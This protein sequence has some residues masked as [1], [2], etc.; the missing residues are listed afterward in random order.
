MMEMK[1]KVFGIDKNLM[2]KIIC[3]NERT[4][5]VE[6][7]DDIDIEVGD[8]ISGELMNYGGDVRLYSSNNGEYFDALI[9]NLDI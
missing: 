3:E 9:Q 6:I 2:L 1:G 4:S 5:L 8:V 7:L